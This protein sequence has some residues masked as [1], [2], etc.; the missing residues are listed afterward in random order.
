M[1]NVADDTDYTALANELAG[2]LAQSVVEQEVIEA[3][4][5]S[6]MTA[7]ERVRPEACSEMQSLVAEFTAN[8]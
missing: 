6:V 4:L 7:F 8:P 5:L 2:L 3:V 1:S